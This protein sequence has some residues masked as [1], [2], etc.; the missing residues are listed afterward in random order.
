MADTLADW[1]FGVGD[2][3]GLDEPGESF[4]EGYWRDG[5]GRWRLGE[6]PADWRQDEDG[7]W[8]P[9]VPPA[10]VRVTRPPAPRAVP[11]PAPWQPPIG[12]ADQDQ[13]RRIGLGDEP[14]GDTVQVTRTWPGWAKLVVP[15][16]VVI[17]GLGVVSAMGGSGGDAAGASDTSAPAT[18]I[19]LPTTTTTLVPPPPLASGSGSAA[20]D[21]PT[22]P[23]GAVAQAA[24]S[25][26]VTPGGFCSPEGAAGVTVDGSPMTCAVG[27]CDGTPYIDQAHWRTA[28]C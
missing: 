14:A 21:A 16:V 15:A 4:G 8:H 19:T 1:G 17:A 20:V 9:T 5:G 12:P 28:D 6:P 11:P 22:E 18:T 27:K 2:V 26:S 10:Q 3:G 13:P 7:R 25:S 24:S 23:V